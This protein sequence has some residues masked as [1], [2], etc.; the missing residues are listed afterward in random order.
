MKIRAADDFHPVPNV[1]AGLFH[2]ISSAGTGRTFE[3]WNAQKERDN[4]ITCSN[5]RAF[6]YIRP[7]TV[8][9]SADAAG[10]P[11]EECK[12]LF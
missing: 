3:R 9:L 5:L 11:L 7:G 8:T 2:L 12:A 4:L 10:S 6:A 1:H